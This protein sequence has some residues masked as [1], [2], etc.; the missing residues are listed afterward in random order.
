[1]LCLSNVVRRAMALAAL[2]FALLPATAQTVIQAENGK[3]AGV[4]P[5]WFI[6]DAD[7]ASAQEIEGYASASSVNT[8]YSA[9]LLLT[10]S[11]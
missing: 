2:V 11:E 3:T 9:K 10:T 4:T 1:M 8:K 5:Q 6:T 7:Y